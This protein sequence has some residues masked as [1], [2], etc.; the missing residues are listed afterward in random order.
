MTGP[1]TKRANRGQ[2]PFSLSTIAIYAGVTLII[3]LAF[4]QVTRSLGKQSLTIEPGWLSKM[5]TGRNFMIHLPPDWRWLDKHNQQEKEA[6]EK[7]YASNSQLRAAISLFGDIDSEIELL[8]I[9]GIPEQGWTSL[10]LIIANDVRPHPLSHDAAATRIQQSEANLI[11]MRSDKLSDD[12]STNTF[13]IELL[14]DGT[15]Y[16]CHQDYIQGTG[17][18]FLVTSC[19]QSRNY[20]AF[21]ITMETIMSTFRPLSP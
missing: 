5:D 21:Q 7:T 15:E 20:A 3:L 19:A 18:T 2:P 12:L 13:V 16:R 11:T 10:F 4:F 6:F 9:A 8:A 14:H 17:K 1:S